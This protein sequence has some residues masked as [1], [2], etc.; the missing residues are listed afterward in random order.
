MIHNNDN[1]KNTELTEPTVIRF[2]HTNKNYDLTHLISI[3]Q[4]HT[5]WNQSKMQRIKNP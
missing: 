2:K 4:K 3:D 1:K 5:L